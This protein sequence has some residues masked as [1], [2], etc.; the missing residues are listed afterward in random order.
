MIL[1]VGGIVRRHAGIACLKRI[2][3][4]LELEKHCHC[5]PYINLVYTDFCVAYVISALPLYTVTFVFH[6]YVRCANYKKKSS[7]LHYT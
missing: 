6:M 5:P 7:L 1:T 3:A 4:I 2:I